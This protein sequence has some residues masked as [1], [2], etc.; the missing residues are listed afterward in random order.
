MPELPDVEILRRYLNR[1]SLQQ[2][3]RHVAIPGKSLLKEVS[4]RKL[5]DTLRGNA[6][7]STE[8][9]GK[10]LFAEISSGSF[11]ALHFGMT[12][13]LAYYKNPSGKPDYVQLL[14]TFSNRYHLAYTA[15]RKLGRISLISAPA[16]FVKDNDLGPDAIEGNLEFEEFQRIIQGSRGRLKSTLMNQSKIAGIGNIYCDE[17]L[18]RSRLRPDAEVSHL[19]RERVKKLH[20]SMGEVLRTAIDRKAN[21]D[22]L[23]RSYL[24]PHRHGDGKCPTCDSGL[25][26]KKI[27]SRTSYYCPNCQKK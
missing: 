11:L 25:K 14:L 20:K 2:K 8:R 6:L 26:Q 10:Y 5:R 16:D 18:F 27:S 15:S 21:P 22:A 24:M 3:I 19:G 13:D 17:I 12:G 9:H 7:E 1:T 23:P 4:A